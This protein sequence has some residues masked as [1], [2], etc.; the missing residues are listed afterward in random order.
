MLKHDRRRQDEEDYIASTGFHIVIDRKTTQR[1]NDSNDKSTLI[2]YCS[3]RWI[4]HIV[5]QY[6]TVA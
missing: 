3:Y 6:E 5:T 1:L 2:S 4:V